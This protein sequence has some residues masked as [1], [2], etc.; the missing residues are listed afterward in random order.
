MY[1]HQQLK[2]DASVFVY[3]YKIMT[4]LISFFNNVLVA[5]SGKSMRLQ[6]TL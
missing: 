3:G 5:A 2:C 1:P 4:G 6:E